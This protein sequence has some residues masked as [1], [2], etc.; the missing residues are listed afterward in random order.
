MW[1]LSHFW[2][3]KGFY[4]YNNIAAQCADFDTATKEARIFI[5]LLKKLELVNFLAVLSTF[6]TSSFLMV[7]EIPGV[8]IV[9]LLAFKRFLLL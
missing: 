5:F 6:G 4:C 2:H 1:L 9:S 7:I 3:S 8:V